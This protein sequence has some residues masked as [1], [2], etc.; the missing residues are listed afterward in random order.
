[1][2]SSK[3]QSSPQLLL[4]TVYPDYEWLPWRFGV[5]PKKYWDDIKH[6]K[7]F[8]DWAGKQLGYKEYS[9]WYSVLQKVI[10]KESF[11]SDFAKDIIELGGAG[12]M[13]KY[14]NSARHMVTSL[15][16]EYNWLPWKFRVLPKHYWENMSNQRKFLDWAANELE[17]KDYTDWYKITQAVL[18]YYKQNVTFYRKYVNLVVCCC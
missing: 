4:S 15:Y 6:H 2:I 17:F 9:D 5:C 7:L 11:K 1:L 18:L 10:N 3:Y 16:P 13:N 12:L 14:Q 8:M